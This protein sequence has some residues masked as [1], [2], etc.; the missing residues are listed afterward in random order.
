MPEREPVGGHP[1]AMNTAIRGE[2][3][4]RLTDTELIER[5]QAGNM[6]ALEVLMRRHNRTLYRTARAILRD[7]AE[8][9]DVVQEA[10]LKAYGALASFR[11]EAKLSTWLV[12]ITA[13]E[14]L[15]RRRKNAR[16]AMVVP[17]DAAAGAG[18]Q[19]W[20]DP[21]S[22]EAGPESDALRG[23]MRRLLEARIDAL[24]DGYRAVFVLRALE[25]LTVEETAAALDIPEP[26]VRTRYFRAR[27]LLRESLARDV[28]RSLE[29]AFSFAGERCDR[30][31]AH[32]L[33]R[34]RAG[35]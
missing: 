29:D 15:M 16:T 18:E 6:R 32:V 14:A 27:G 26:T 22:E 7:D 11:G 33:E 21:M 12:R 10:Y 5:T 20:E 23:E 13:N 35:T 3:A 8:A 4:E 1:M 2:A 24:P 30:I 28:D 31:V 9:E 34:I 19:Q 17:M 25:E